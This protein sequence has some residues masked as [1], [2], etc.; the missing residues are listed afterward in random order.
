MSKHKEIYQG[1]IYDADEGG[2]HFQDKAIA[3]AVLQ[4]I[5][6]YGSFLSVHYWIANQPINPETV[7]QDWLTQ[8][9]TGT[10][11]AEYQIHSSERTGYLWT[12][13]E[14]NVG[15]HDLLAE[16]H[17]HIGKYIYMEIEYSKHLG[18]TKEAE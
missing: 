3:K 18:G 9:Y 10:G 15:G 8:L 17:T 14:L 13:E 1:Y 11:A 7:I 4:T 16:L 12:D 2:L 6:K 5:S